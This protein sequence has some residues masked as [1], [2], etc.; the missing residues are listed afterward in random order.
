MERSGSHNLDSEN[1]IIVVSGLPRSGTSVMMQMLEAADVPIL[2]DEARKPDPSNPNGY[3]ELE[4][5]KA[6]ARDAS[7]ID[8]APGHAVKVIHALIPALPRDR[9]YRVILMLRNLQEV[10]ASQ[11]QMLA[12]TGQAAGELPPARLAEIF[13][14]QLDETRGTLEREPC[15]AWLEV[16]H[17]DLL[18]DAGKVASR[19]SRFLNLPDSATTPDTA[20]CEA[21]SAVVD[22]NLYRARR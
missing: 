13:A 2:C 12:E 19:V 21:M 5:V 16:Q 6:S 17:A 3:Y 10:I 15:F 14:Q 7:W 22:P 4:A 9:S 18:D 11:A 1:Q 20:R 8:R